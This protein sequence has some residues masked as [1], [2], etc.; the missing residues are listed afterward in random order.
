MTFLP[1][2]FQHKTS[3]NTWYGCDAT[4]GKISQP[5]WPS[6]ALYSK[7]LPKM[8]TRTAD[9][10]RCRSCFPNSACGDSSGDSG[11]EASPASIKP[12]LNPSKGVLFGA[13]CVRA[14]VNESL[15]AGET[16]KTQCANITTHTKITD[17]KRQTT[18]EPNTNPGTWLQGG[19]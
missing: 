8:C 3:A 18:R 10:N 5:V 17:S 7:K 16:V 4:T 14:C 12:T 13:R 19:L 15:G 9:L 11:Y 1:P 2:G 6:G